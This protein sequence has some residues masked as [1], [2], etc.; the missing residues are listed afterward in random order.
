MPLSHCWRRMLYEGPWV[1]V[2]GAVAQLEEYPP[3]KREVAG[4]SPTDTISWRKSELSVEK[5]LRLVLNVIKSVTTQTPA[6]WCLFMLLDFRLYV[7]PEGFEPSRH[8][9]DLGRQL[10]SSQTAV[11]LL[12]TQSTKPNSHSTQ[13]KYQKVLCVCVCVCVCKPREGRGRAASNKKMKILPRHTQNIA[14]LADFGCLPTIIP[15]LNRLPHIRT[16]HINWFRVL[17]LFNDIEHEPQGLTYYTEFGF[18]Q[19]NGHR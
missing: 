6:K 17:T 7:A 10:L 9:L 18:P 1:R 11:S 5:S 4:S 2:N 8:E 12:T 19:R 16:L 15:P 3:G 14:R 13:P